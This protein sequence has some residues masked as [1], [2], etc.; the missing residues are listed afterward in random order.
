MKLC[1]EDKDWLLGIIGDPDYT[2]EVIG[3]IEN[4]CENAFMDGYDCGVENYKED[5]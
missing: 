3:H 5:Y 1:Q 2:Q 4:L